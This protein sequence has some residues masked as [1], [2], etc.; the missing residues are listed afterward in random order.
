MVTSAPVAPRVSG[1]WSRAVSA[2]IRRK[3]VGLPSGWWVCGSRD[4]ASDS[5]TAWGGVRS[6]VR[7]MVVR[8]RA[9]AGPMAATLGG[10]GAA[11]TRVR[12][13]GPG[14]PGSVAGEV[15]RRW[16]A[17]TALA[18]V[19]RSQW[20]VS[21]AESA[22]SRTAKLVGSV[23]S[24]VGM[25]MGSKPNV[26]R[27]SASSEAWCGERVIRMRGSGTGLIGDCN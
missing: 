17:S 19:N 27:R 15:R 16:K 9:V 6:G 21:R 13:S 8:A 23:S 22:V 18:L 24:M 3:R 2:R 12:E 20:K 14:A 4:S 11:E 1:R 5:A 26:R 25:R 7:P 10:C